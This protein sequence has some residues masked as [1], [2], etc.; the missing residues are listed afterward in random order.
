LQGAR[1]GG[2]FSRSFVKATGYVTVIGWT[3]CLMIAFLAHPIIYV[4]FGPQWVGAVD[5]AR[6]LA[7]AM[8]FG[9]QS[10]FLSPRWSPLGR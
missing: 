3:F 7:T 2:D 4:L 5:L 8:A 1:E 10:R 9:V 6:V